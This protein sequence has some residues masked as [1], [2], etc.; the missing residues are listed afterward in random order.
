M[1]IFNQADV[2]YYLEENSDLVGYK[3]R[4]R[5]ILDRRNYI[6]HILYYKFK[7]SEEK[8]ATILK[9]KRPVVQSAK[10]HAY[11]FR[12]DAT[13]QLNIE[14]IKR[15]FPFRPKKSEQHKV[16]ELK[17]VIVS[18]DSKEYK[19]LLRFKGRHEVHTLEQAIKKMI[20]IY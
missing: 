17:R 16:I 13:F 5:Y 18:L 14:R 8:V 1:N 6:I 15:V 3:G 7:L 2:E 20:R 9:I 12:N 11:T 4:K 10:N 19:K